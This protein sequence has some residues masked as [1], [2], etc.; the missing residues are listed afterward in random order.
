M[1]KCTNICMINNYNK[2]LLQW[3]VKHTWVIHGT[4]NHFVETLFPLVHYLQLQLQG[5]YIQQATLTTAILQPL[6]LC[7]LNFSGLLWIPI[8]VS[9]CIIMLLRKQYRNIPSKAVLNNFLQRQFHMR[10]QYNII[11]IVCT[12]Q[13]NLEFLIN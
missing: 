5:L 2:I 12:I 1:P 11:C 4:I 13:Y 7:L 10:M 9:C 6:S 8:H 3:R